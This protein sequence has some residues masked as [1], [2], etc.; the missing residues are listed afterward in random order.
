MTERLRI[1]QVSG[2]RV[3]IPPR[4]AFSPEH[5]IH[6]LCTALTELG[7]EATLIDGAGARPNVPYR[8]IEIPSGPRGNVALPKALARGLLFGVNVRRQ[9]KELLGHERFDVVNFHFQFPAIFS[10]P[11]AR[12]QNVPTVYWVHSPIWGARLT[13]Q[14]WSNRVSFWPE[15][16]V[17]RSVDRIVAE[18]RTTAC[19]IRG[20]LGLAAHSVEVIPHGLADDWFLPYEES[21]AELGADWPDGP[22][23]LN[24]GI[25]DPR[26]NQNLLIQA[27]PLVLEQ[28][29]TAKFVFAGPVLDRRYAKHLQELVNESGVQERVRFVGD[30]PR[31]EVRG[32]YH[33]SSLFVFTSLGE[34][35]PV[36][37][38][39]AMAS[40]VPILMASPIEAQD[41]LPHDCAEFA[42]DG[43]HGALATAIVKL[44]NSRAT[45]E[46]LRD[47]G[48]RYAYH[49]HRWSAVIARFVDLYARLAEQNGAR[50]VK[51]RGD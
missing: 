15:R 21:P 44:L 38:L 39:E 29:P 23:V 19:N 12:D 6:A 16:Y 34:N 28:V 26:K 22:L 20:E 18:T 33:S 14:A 45:K 37:L 8:V 42:P 17:L 5:S 46:R 4:G 50:I 41:V 47:V 1:L 32:W 10:I 36:V 48:W 43:D 51:E 7:H 25:I 3:P 9:L 49:T 40:R 35:A 27:I 11:V 30:V 24:V 13:A 2:G 31:D